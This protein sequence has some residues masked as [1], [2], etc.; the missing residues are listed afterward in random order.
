MMNQIEE[1]IVNADDVKKE[2]IYIDNLY[3]DLKNQIEESET[4]N[5]DLEKKLAENEEKF[6]TLLAEFQSFKTLVKESFTS[7]LEEPSVQPKVKQNMPFAS[8]KKQNLFKPK[9][10]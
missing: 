6:N 8:E 10:F 7:L 4:K 3:N 9:N 2:L 1:N 5:K